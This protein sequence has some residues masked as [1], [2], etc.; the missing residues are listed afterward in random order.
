[1]KSR[2][3]TTLS[4][5]TLLAAATAFAQS[6][7]VMHADIPFE[8][9]VGKTVLPAGH[10]DV[11]PNY[12]NGIL[13]LGCREC[14]AEAMVQ[15][16]GTQSMSMQTSGKLIF[17]RYGDQYFLSTVWSPGSDQ[18]SGVRETNAERK[19]TRNGSPAVAAVIEMTRR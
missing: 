3:F 18:G 4:S 10:Y 1:M 5:L 8:F 17:H 12:M 14:K 2:I 19:M 15:T 11:R 13:F 9:S 7:S 16:I 6:G